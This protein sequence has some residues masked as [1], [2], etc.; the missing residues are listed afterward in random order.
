[1]AIRDYIEAYENSKY[2][3]KQGSRAVAFMMNLINDE[4]TTEEDIR[5][6]L[7]IING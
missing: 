6:F 2:A 3:G 7:E 1:M 5:E 4:D